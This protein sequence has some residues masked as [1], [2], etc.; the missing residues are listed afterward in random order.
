MSAGLIYPKCMDAMVNFYDDKKGSMKHS[1][2]FVTKKFTELWWHI[3][4]PYM[5]INYVNMQE[6][7]VNMQE[8]HVNMQ[9]NYVN[10]QVTNVLG[11]SDFNIGKITCV[12]LY[13]TL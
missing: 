4:A 12:S 11:E 2:I 6:N 3:S 1:K 7:Y 9:D 5:K 10:M 13:L 8:N